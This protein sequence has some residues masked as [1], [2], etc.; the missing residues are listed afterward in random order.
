MSGFTTA[1]D[2]TPRIAIVSDSR[3]AAH[4]PLGFHP[5]RPRRLEAALTGAANAMKIGES[6]A[7]SVVSREASL[8]ELTRVHD[9]TWL[10]RL[11]ASLAGPAGYLDSDTYFNAATR[12]AAWLASGS[13]CALVESQFKNESDVTFLFARPPGHHAMRARAMGFCVLNHVA[14]AAAHALTLGA[15]KVAIVDWDV[16]HGNGTQDILYRNPAVLFISMHESPMFPDTGYVRETGEDD[17]R[18]TTVN[19]PL[20]GGCDGGAYAKVFDRI[21]LPILREAAPD[22]ILVSAGFDAHTNDPIATMLLQRS[23]YRWMAAQ[24]QTVARES[25]RGRLGLVFEGGYDLTA[26]EESVEDTL[27]G[28]IHPGSAVQPKITAQSSGAD[29]VIRAVQRAHGPFWQCLR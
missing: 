7:I 12:E 1:H 8:H 3:F 5:E 29:A 18:G 2:P 13:A 21:V 23:D 20:P 27:L 22:L 11:Q 25:A 9:P 10:E 4:E 28:L 16:H 26:V 15:K 24:L 19:V 6:T 14:V 17:G